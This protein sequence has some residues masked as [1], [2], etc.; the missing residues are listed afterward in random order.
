VYESTT[1]A[2]EQRAWCKRLLK[3]CSPSSL[4]AIDDV[5]TERPGSPIC[6]PWT[7]TKSYHFITS[8]LLTSTLS[9]P[10]LYMQ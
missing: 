10:V 1:N 5:R 8:D 3:T 9:W 2:I 6:W 7:S 4:R